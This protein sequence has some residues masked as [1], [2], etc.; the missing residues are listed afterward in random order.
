MESMEDLLT[1]RICM[2]KYN[3]NERKPLFLP[4][5][6]TFCQKCLKFVYKRGKLQCPMDKKK[7]SFDFFTSIPSN[8]QL[9]NCLDPFS[10]D[11]EEQKVS[12]F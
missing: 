11:Q 5:G 9:L 4:C 1:C 10:D 12:Q 3:T 7:H 2:E 8:F 6:H